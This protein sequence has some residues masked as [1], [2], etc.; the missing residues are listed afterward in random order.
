MESTLSKAQQAC[1]FVTCPCFVPPVAVWWQIWSLP[2][3]ESPCSQC[4]AVYQQNVTGNQFY[5]CRAFQSP[6]TQ[7]IHGI[8]LW[9]FKC[10]AKLEVILRSGPASGTSVNC[11]AG[12]LST[13]HYDHVQPQLGSPPCGI[14]LA[15]GGQTGVLVYPMAQVNMWRAWFAP[16]GPRCW[17]GSSPSSA[18]KYLAVSDHTHTPSTRITG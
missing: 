13:R 17:G 11:D 9:P 3:A 15:V 14:K 18:I 8:P 1:H 6:K 16:Q 12:R 5:F 2:S 10:S 7:S 4:E